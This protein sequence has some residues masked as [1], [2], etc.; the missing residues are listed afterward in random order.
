MKFLY[1]D[2]LDFVDPNYNFLEDRSQPGRKPYWDDE[3][4]HEHTD[5]PPFD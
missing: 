2:G 4:M 1:A 3:F 5:E